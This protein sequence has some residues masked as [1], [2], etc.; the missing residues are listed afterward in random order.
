GVA[1]R[2]RC[3]GRGG[4]W[5]GPGAEAQAQLPEGPG[6][7]ANCS[8]AVALEIARGCNASRPPVPRRGNL[9][10]KAGDLTAILFFDP[11]LRRAIGRA[12]PHASR[13]S[14]KVAG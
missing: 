6:W 2:A 7:Q 13:W 3:T 14:E 1:A 9:L 10:R 12:G 11:C 5:A 8:L 4:G